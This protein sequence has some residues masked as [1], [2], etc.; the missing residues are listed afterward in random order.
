MLNIRGDVS[1]SVFLMTLSIFFIAFLDLCSTSLLLWP[2]TNILAWCHYGQLQDWQYS[3]WLIVFGIG[4]HLSLLWVM[5]HGCLEASPRLH[6][7][8]LLIWGLASVLPLWFESTWLSP[9]LLL[10]AIICLCW[11][12]APDVLHAKKIDVSTAFLVSGLLLASYQL[13]IEI[14]GLAW[15]RASAWISWWQGEEALFLMI[16]PVF[17]GVMY[18]IIAQYSNKKLHK[19]LLIAHWISTLLLVIWCHYFNGIAWP[20]ELRLITGSLLMITM[21]GGGLYMLW[22]LFQLRHTWQNHNALFCLLASVLMYLFY[23]SAILLMS[24]SPSHAL[25]SFTFWQEA[26]SYRSLSS[27]PILVMFALSF[28]FFNAQPSLYTRWFIRFYFSAV[29]LFQL[30]AWNAGVI[31]GIM[32]R[33]FGKQADLYYSH[34]ETVQ[35]MPLFHFL[36]WTSSILL[37]V[38]CVLMLLHIFHIKSIAGNQH[39]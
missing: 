16:S 5:Q 23:S 33:T 21:W 30:A 10:I 22:H 25:L 34:L 17:I 4:L 18:S 9:V 1:S 3:M 12:I 2:E 32:W 13:I 19:R 37:M 11:S 28:A 39:A 26:I 8:F 35:A 38:A 7:A 14:A 24:W 27:W 20:S 31:Q 6:T 36:Q 15:L 29:I